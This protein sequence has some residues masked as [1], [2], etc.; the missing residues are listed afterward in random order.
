MSGRYNGVQQKLSDA[1][2]FVIHVLCAAHL[3]NLVE[4]SAVDY[5]QV[6]D[7]FS[8]LQLLYKF[9]S[10]LQMEKLISKDYM[11]KILKSLSGTRW[12]THMVAL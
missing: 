7:I 9:F 6:V 1:N 5:W 12:D 11:E 10:T 2:Q 8:S 4:H 3:L